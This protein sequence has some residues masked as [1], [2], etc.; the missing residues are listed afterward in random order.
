MLTK[1][2]KGLDKLPVPASSINGAAQHATVQPLERAY[3]PE[4]DLT[5]LSLDELSTSPLVYNSELTWLDFNWRV[6]HEALD[7]RTPLLER[8][9]FLAITSSNLDE[10]FRK[11]VGGLKRQKAAGIANLTLQGWTP[12]LQLQLIAKGVHPMVDAQSRALHDDILP[13]LAEDDVRIIDYTGLDTRQQQRLQRYFESEVYPILTPLAFDPGHPFPFLSN[14][15]LSLG[16]LLHDPITNE[17]HFARVKVPAN[18]PRWVP[19]ENARHFVPLEQIIMH[20]L[21]LL[22]QGMEI[23]AAYPFRVTR[24]AD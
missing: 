7:P 1:Q 19:L 9:K 5:T 21:A 23:V 18:R 16:V 14:M 6:L 13:A 20:H 8:L 22:F 17:S 24:N 15:S 3:Q 11:R 4:I 12:D 2:R 10:F